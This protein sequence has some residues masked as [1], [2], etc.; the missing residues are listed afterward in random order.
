MSEAEAEDWLGVAVG[1]VLDYPAGILDR[2]SLEARRS[3]THHSQ[4]VPTIVREADVL[5]ARNASLRE[6][7]VPSNLHVLPAPRRLP[8]PKLTQADVD[9]MDAKLIE[10]GISCGA[11][12]RDADGNVGP[13]PEAA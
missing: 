3:C 4:I 10:I 13:A 11:L 12:V 1:T 6:A 5:M 9:A 8:P 7:S 2:A